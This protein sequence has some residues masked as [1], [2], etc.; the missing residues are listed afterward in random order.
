MNNWLKRFALELQ[1]LFLFSLR[2]IGAQFTRPI[3]FREFQE[4]L[5]LVGVG[6]L[7]LIILAG[8]FAGQG[9]AIAFSQEL[10]DFGAKNYLGRIL[11]IAIFRELGPVLTGLMVAARVSAGIT[12]EIGAMKSSNQIDAMIAFGIDPVKKITVPRLW[13]LLIMVPALTIICDAVAILGGWMIGE[14]VANVPSSLYWTNV[15]DR[16]VFGNLFMGII[17]PVAFALIIAFI[18]CYKGFSSTGGTKGVGKA[19]TESVVM[20]SIVI[21]IVN[22]MLTKIVGSLIKGWI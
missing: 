1:R 18:S 2:M 14:L 4:Q 17:K 21:L 22:F 6:S 11:A 8:A 7:Y 5:Y 9:F 16:L 10:A 13:A 3:Y 12:A 19:T 15:R 20:S